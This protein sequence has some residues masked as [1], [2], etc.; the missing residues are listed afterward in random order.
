MKKLIL[1]LK[2]KIILN[3]YTNKINSINKINFTNKIS[4][5]HRVI[6]TS[7]LPTKKTLKKYNNNILINNFIYNLTLK[8]ISKDKKHNNFTLD[9]QTRNIHI[10]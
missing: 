5:N 1:K 10:K 9:K 6:Q 2:K 3:N 4:R 7:I 8:N